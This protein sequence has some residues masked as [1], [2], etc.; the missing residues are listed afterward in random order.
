LQVMLLQM[1]S[2]RK[3]LADSVVTE[4]VIRPLVELNFG[5]GDIPRYRFSETQLD[6]FALG[7]L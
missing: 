7:A 2:L 6:A 3:E 5:P 4:Q 1:A